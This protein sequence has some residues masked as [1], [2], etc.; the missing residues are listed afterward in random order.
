MESE[1]FRRPKTVPAIVQIIITQAV[2]HRAASAISERVF[3]EQIRRIAREELE[4]RGLILLV[5]ELPAGRT[6]FL[7][8]EQDTGTVCDMLEFAADGL[9]ER[10]S[11]GSSGKTHVIG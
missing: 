5:R 6:R 10:V 4:P 2:W 9:P 1:I 3:E 8:K 7:V 11:A